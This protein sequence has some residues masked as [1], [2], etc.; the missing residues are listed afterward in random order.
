MY[1]ITSLT[2]VTVAC[3]VIAPSVLAGKRG[4]AWPWYNERTHLDPGK[5]I[6]DNVQWMYN[7][8]TW[9]PGNT[10]GFNWIGTQATMDSPSSPVGQLKARAEQQGW[11]TVFSLNEPDING[12]SPGAAASW[13]IKY[14]NPLAI[15]KAIP[16]VTSSQDPRKG[17]DWAVQFLRACGGLCYFDYINI[18]WYGHTFEQFRSHVQHA[19]DVF[20]NHKLVVTEFALQRPANRDQQLWFLKAAMEFM[21]HADYVAMYSVFVASS[22]S[23]IS[24]NMGGE[25]VGI[26]SSLYNDDGSLTDNGWA[27]RNDR[28]DGLTLQLQ[29]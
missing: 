12:I 1:P 15:K 27:Y 6:G 3:F 23:L 7:W 8:E 19:H 5:L 11:N 13:Y 26:G 29:G 17:L 21:D 2:T 25:E 20:P 24:R 18:H 22:P 9:R 4:I 14:I 28:W 16:A 10:N